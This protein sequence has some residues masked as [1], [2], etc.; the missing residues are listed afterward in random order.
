MRLLAIADL[1]LRYP[2]NREALERLPAHP[3][4]WLVVAGDIGESEE[5]LHWALAR[6]TARFARVFWVPGNHDLWSVPDRAGELAGEAKYLRQVAICRHYG[7]A[8]PEDPYLAWPG[9]GPRCLIAP[10]FLLYDYSFRPASVALEDVLAWAAEDHVLSADEALLRPDP[11]P[12]RAAWCAARLAATVPRLEAAAREAPLVLVNH[13]PLRYDLVRLKRIPRFSPW[14]GTVATEDWHRRFRA[15]AV[16]HGHLHIRGTH[17]R[18][19]VRFDEVSLGYP[20][21]WDPRLGLERYLRPILP[22]S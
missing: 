21:D 4:D 2:Q 17:W 7:V 18:D 20:R 14:C 22:A 13:F 9:P 19:G 1:H 12:S 5:L 16:V 10:L 6:L 3:A 8:T 11:Y 15:V